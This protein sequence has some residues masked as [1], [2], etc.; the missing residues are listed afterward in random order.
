MMQISL[1]LLQ[2]YIEFYIYFSNLF[3]MSVYQTNQ[4][5]ALHFLNALLLHFVFFGQIM[6]FKLQFVLKIYIHL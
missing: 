5:V 3:K 6:Y 2:L 4:N 1:I